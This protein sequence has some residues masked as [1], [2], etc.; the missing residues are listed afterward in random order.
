ME[1]DNQ[2][3]YWDR[4]AETK[5]FTHPLDLA[6]LQRHVAPTAHVLDYGCGYGRIV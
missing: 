2:H 5:Q 3:P 6:L 1:I 4:V